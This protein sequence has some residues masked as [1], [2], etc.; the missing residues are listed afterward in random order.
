[1]DKEA[2]WFDKYLTDWKQIVELRCTEKKSTSNVKSEL[3]QQNRGVPQRSVL[4]PILFIL[5]TN[6]LLDPQHYVT[7]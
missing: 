4:G 1:M 5:L 6:N 3:L 7:S 2:K